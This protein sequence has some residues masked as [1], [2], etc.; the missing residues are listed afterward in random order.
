MKSFSPKS[1]LKATRVGLGMFSLASTLLANPPE[2]SAVGNHIEVK[3]PDTASSDFRMIEWSPDLINWEPIARRHGAS[4]ENLFPYALPIRTTGSNQVLTD[5]PD[6]PS[7][8]YRVVTESGSGLSNME[9]ASRFLQQA[10]FGPTRNMMASFPGITEPSGFNEAPYVFF[11]QWITAEMAKPVGSLRAYWRQRSNPDFV[12]MTGNSPSEVGHNPAYGQEFSYYSS[13]TVD[14]SP[15]IVTIF[16]TKQAI[17]YHHAI[18]ADDA[19]RQ[20]AAWAL[21]QIFVMSTAGFSGT[22]TVECWLAY[23]DIFQ[24]NAFGNFR[25]IL[26]KVTYHPMMGDYLSYTNNQKANTSTGTFPDENYAR[27]I[28]QLFTIGLWLLNQD[29]TA[30]LDA[31]GNQI[32]TYDNDDIFEFAKIFTGFRKQA[33]RDNVENKNGT[34]NRVD[35]MRLQSSWHDFTRKKLL[36]YD[37]PEGPAT[38][39]IIG[40]FDSNDAGMREEVSVFLDHLFNHPNTAPFI[41]RN[42]IQRMTVSNPSPQY[43]HDVAGAFISGSY[44]GTGSNQRGDMG[45]VFRAILLHP[46]ARNPSLSGDPGHGRLREPLIRLISVGRAFNLTPSP[47]TVNWKTNPLEIFTFKNTDEIVGQEPFGSPSVFNF[48]L[49]DFQPPGI[50]SDRGL[51]AP[52]FEIHTDVL[53]ITLQN[54][55]HEL[56]MDDYKP[57]LFYNSAHSDLDLSYEIS[58]AAD[59]PSGHHALINHAATMLAP[60][61]LLETNRATIFDAIDAINGNSNSDREKRVRLTLWL[62]TLLP[63]F[64]TLQ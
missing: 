4:W 50:I 58:L 20:R 25:D 46:E 54:A 30:V 41:A 57:T 59:N 56:V 24:R 28:M 53:A 31:N 6:Q 17:W 49:P 47:G 9:A 27:E 64:N 61:R 3:L 1:R 32:P 19:L 10:T 42:L 60:G 39:P 13:G 22:D 16:N 23:Y 7:G 14:P 43:I 52:E 8:Y 15:R 18:S 38:A 48:Y 35:P 26:E 51:Y 2:V 11:D 21:S 36:D 62:I 12:N 63:E 44:N 37:G 34:G 45:A 55:L 33:N 40:P 5:Y 29:G